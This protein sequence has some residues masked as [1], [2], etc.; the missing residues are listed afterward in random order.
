MACEAVGL[1][2]GGPS[3]PQRLSRGMRRRWD[4]TAEAVPLRVCGGDWKGWWLVFGAEEGG[5]VTGETGG[6]AHG[7]PSVPQRLKPG[8][9]SEVGWHG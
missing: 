1:A 7:G 2:H 8:N 5:A 9:A 4:G 6:L 3:V